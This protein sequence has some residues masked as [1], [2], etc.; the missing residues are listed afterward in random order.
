MTW[1]MQAAALLVGG[2]FF[3]AVPPTASPVMKD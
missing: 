1:L 2:I 3:D